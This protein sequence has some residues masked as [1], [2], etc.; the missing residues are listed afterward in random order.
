MFSLKFNTSKLSQ[1]QL[2]D[3]EKKFHQNLTLDMSLKLNVLSLNRT[4]LYAH[5]LSLFVRSNVHKVLDLSVSQLLDFLIDVAD[6]YTEAPYHTFYHAVDIVT[7]LYYLCHDLNADMYLTDLDK[8]ILLVA[9]LCHDIGHPGFTNSFQINTKTELA[10]KYGETSTLETY[11]VH[12]TME[13]LSKH[14]TAH[15]HVVRDTIKDLILSTDMAYHSE[16]IKQADQLVHLVEQA[17]K[18]SSNKRKHS[19]ST[20]LMPPTTL[21]AESRTSLC[22]ILLHAADISNMARPWVISKQ[23]SDLIVQEFFSQGDEERKRKM[24]ISPGM[25]REVCSQPSISLK[26]GQLI[27]PYFES[28]VSLFSKSHVFVDFLVANRTRWERLDQQKQSPAPTITKTIRRVSSDIRATST[29]VPTATTT[30]IAAATATAIKYKRI[31]LGFR[32][33]LL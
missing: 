13:L 33:T 11:S 5:A 8:S 31:R 27:L 29:T 2:L 16:L 14:N 25:D 26:F 12:L 15:S 18:S 10:G 7:I 23:W 6:K 17:R 21:S 19:T 24:T 32:T 28:L 22:R 3:I 20:T 1:Q 30:T 4:D 9:A